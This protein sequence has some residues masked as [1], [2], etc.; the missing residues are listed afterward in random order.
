MFGKIM[1]PIELEQAMLVPEL[2]IQKDM[3]GSYIL[4]VTPENM[5]ESRYLELGPRYE[6]QRIIKSGLDKDE[7]VI[8]Q[9]LQRA[10]PGIEVQTGPPSSDST[11][12]T[13]KD[14]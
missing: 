11:A 3:V 5:V 12:A 8:I 9:G 6:D 1:L 2:S 10:R 14:S 13:E 7:Q 4:V